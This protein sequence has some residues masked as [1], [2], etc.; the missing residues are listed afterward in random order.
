MDFM[1]LFDI[2]SNGGCLGYAIL[3]LEALGYKPEEIRVIVDAVK[4][5]FDRRT[6]QEADKHYCDSA[7]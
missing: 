6:V 5:Q 2:W 3:A 4:R 7:Y 1:G